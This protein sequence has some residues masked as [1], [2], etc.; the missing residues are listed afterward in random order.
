MVQNLRL[1]QLGVKKMMF[2]KRDQKGFTLIE[3]M[4]V[5]IIIGIIAIIALPKLLVT[6]EV[7]RE[8]SCES[9]MQ[10]IRTA[11]EQYKWDIDDY[12]AGP[13][14]N[15]VE[16]LMLQNAN[17]DSLE[18]FGPWLPADSSV[19]AQCPS[20]LDRY[21]YDAGTGSFTCTTTDHGN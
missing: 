14:A 16:Q 4:L 9:N 15:L 12:P 5:V 6:R 1:D 8:K 10:A 19:S 13:V 2:V 7:A 20:G 17:P 21:R 18:V 11:I 3:V